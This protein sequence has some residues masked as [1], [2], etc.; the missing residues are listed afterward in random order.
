MDSPQRD[1]FAARVLEILRETAGTDE[2]C[3]NL[4]L[5]LY[6]DGLLDS[7]ATVMLMA[8]FA[9]RLQIDVSPAEFDVNA[10]GT[11]RLL[12]DDLWRRTPAGRPEA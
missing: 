3:T 1:A 9:D 6:T 8:A 10:W 2:V 11:P 12:I 4:D 5:P 7:L